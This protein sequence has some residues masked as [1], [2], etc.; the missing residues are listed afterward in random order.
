[1]KY[2]NIIKYFFILLLGLV[3]LTSSNALGD[4]KA[5]QTGQDVFVLNLDPVLHIYPD[6]SQ[7]AFVNQT[8]NV[9]HDPHRTLT[10]AMIKMLTLR[11]GADSLLSIVHIG[12][13]H[14]QAG[15]WGQRIRALFQNDF[16]NAGRGLI[17]P[18]KLAKGNEPSDYYIRTTKPFETSKATSNGFGSPLSFTGTAVWQE[19]KEAEFELWSKSPFDAVTVFHHPNAPMLNV[20][21][22]LTPG[23][24]CTAYNTL[25]TTRIVLSEH[26]DTLA[27][28]G[29]CD[30]TYNTPLYYGFSLENGNPGVLYHDIGS[31]GAA[32]EHYINN[33]TVTQG[34]VA[35]LNPDIIIVSLG[36]NNCYG[37]NYR[38]AN[39]RPVIERFVT[40]IKENYPNSAIIMTTPRESC[41]R[42]GRQY[43]P[44]P[45]IADAAEL[46]KAVAL[47]KGVAYWDFYSAAGGKNVS[48]KW[49]SEGL[50]SRD[51][52]HLTEKG[53]AFAGDMLYDAM[54]LY[55]NQWLSDLAEHRGYD[56]EDGS[57]LIWSE[58]MAEVN[59]AYMIT[60]QSNGDTFISAEGGAI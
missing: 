20:P 24:Y 22:S 51:R 27:I 3:T 32:F 57:K 18:Y 43:K 6:S 4:P 30:N 1:M 31:N 10:P 50:A 59:K 58:D 47:D 12:D 26:K 54:T 60:G 55:Y 8:A 56:P 29:Y 53:Y 11:S 33:T 23:S 37:R 7:L 21:D 48:E 44:N 15:F 36:T 38:S 40:R 19:E 34:G 9:I 25:E 13:S 2:K 39:L 35:A 45:N 28:K 52:I 17:I 49:Y 5:E 14:V 16:G 46:I 42:S 41:K